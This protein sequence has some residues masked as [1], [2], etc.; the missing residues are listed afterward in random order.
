MDD[1]VH[2]G[3]TDTEDDFSMTAGSRLLGK[4]KAIDY[5]HGPRCHPLGSKLTRACDVKPINGDSNRGN[6]NELSR[7]FF[8]IVEG[9]KISHRAQSSKVCRWFL[10]GENQKN[11]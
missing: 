10:K 7:V 5:P 6:K 4:R 8:W 1:V 2:D 11:L 3:N 9:V